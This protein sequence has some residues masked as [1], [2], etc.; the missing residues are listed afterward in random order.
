MKLNGYHSCSEYMAE[1]KRTGSRPQPGKEE[2]IEKTK[3][4]N[5]N[6]PDRQIGV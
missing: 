4:V 5:T 6:I 1:F 2:L 3:N